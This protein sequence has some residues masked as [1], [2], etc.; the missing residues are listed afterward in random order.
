[1]DFV[2]NLMGDPQRKQDFDNFADRYDQG[3]PSEGYDDQEVVERH[4]QVASQLSPDD[5]QAAAQQAFDRL[6]PE[7]RT[8]FG[9]HLQQQAQQ[10][11]VADFG[12][13]QAGPQQF[14][15]SGF[16]ANVAG[17]MHQQPSGLMG[18]LAGGGMAGGMMGGGG[19]GLG[20]MLGGGGGGGGSLL[21]NPMA[22]AAM[23]G[24]ARFAW[25][26]IKNR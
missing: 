6:S 21:S 16:L 9:Q 23:A 10:Q 14:Q 4:Q 15:N 1:M 26:Q 25:Q 11:G 12:L 19:G 13:M 8:Q 24:I 2:N 3:H 22:K 18:M 5:Y 17:Q 7:E 20:S